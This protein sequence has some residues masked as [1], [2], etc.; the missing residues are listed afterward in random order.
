MVIEALSLLCI[1]CATGQ[2]GAVERP[3][4][5]TQP[6]VAA[7]AEDLATVAE[8]MLIYIEVGEGRVFTGRGPEVRLP[9][10][11]TYARGHSEIAIG[12]L[13]AKLR[14][15]NANVRFNAYDFLIC[16]ADVPAAHDRALALLKAGQEKEGLAQ[17]AFIAAALD[18]LREGSS[19]TDKPPA[20]QGNVN[21]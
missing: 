13:K 14:S 15:E 5:A 3:T 9:I 20:D 12:L 7:P 4:A 2:A 8:T 1:G 11:Y 17:Q 6:V 21:Y 19:K 16:L 10:Y 18:R